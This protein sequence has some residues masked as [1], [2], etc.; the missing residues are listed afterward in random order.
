MEGRSGKIQVVPAEELMIAIR[1]KC[2]GG[3]L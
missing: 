3:T 2:R 1:S